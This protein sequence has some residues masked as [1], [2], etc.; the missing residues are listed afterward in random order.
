MKKQF[1]LILFCLVALS[2]G[3]NR[4]RATG[5]IMVMAEKDPN[6]KILGRI[7]NQTPV[8]VIAVSHKWWKI[9]YNGGEAYV[10]GK[11]LKQ[12]GSS[13]RLLDLEDP[14][15]IF[16][17][18]GSV[19]VIITIISFTG[20]RLSP[21]YPIPGSSQLS[22]VN[23]SP[24]SYWYQCMHCNASIRNSAEPRTTGCS[25]AQAHS[26]INLGEAGDIK[27]LCKKCSTFVAMKSDP[28]EDGCLRGDKHEWRKF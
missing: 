14:D 6:S 18:I 27:Y 15:T 23:K 5:E 1:L 13:G 12:A 4:Y 10:Q 7:Q 19:L 11:Y 9:K 20:H 8:D 21:R 28:G 26:W 17:I 24:F 16:I 2:A 25:R 22:K 3:A